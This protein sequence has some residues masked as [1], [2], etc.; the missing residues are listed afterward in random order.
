[1]AAKGRHNLTLNSENVKRLQKILEYQGMS[2]SSYVDS[3]IDE[4]ALRRYR[5][6]HLPLAPAEMDLKHL[7]KTINRAVKFMEK[8]NR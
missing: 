1:M 8:A 2:L 5:K 3:V 6:N 7:Q 4:E